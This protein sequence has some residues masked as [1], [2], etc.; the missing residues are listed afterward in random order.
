VGLVLVST[1]G[2]NEI[3]Q[4]IGAPVMAAALAEKGTS[5][6]ITDY[7]YSA[8]ALY[9][10]RFMQLN[11]EQF[12]RI[13]GQVESVFRKGTQHLLEFLGEKRAQLIAQNQDNVVFESGSM[14]LRGREDIH[15]GEYVSLRLGTK[16][17]GRAGFEQQA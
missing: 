13:D 3:T 1:G 10:F 14:A 17:S 4:T 16:G 11:T 5:S 8:A 6:P 7:P 9:G 15:A 2:D 12:P